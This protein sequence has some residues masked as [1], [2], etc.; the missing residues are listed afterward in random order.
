MP[1]G[2]PGPLWAVHDADRAPDMAAANPV[3]ERFALCP[4]GPY[5][6]VV[7]AGD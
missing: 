5:H 6:M 1:L 7:L 3:T 4:W 2:S